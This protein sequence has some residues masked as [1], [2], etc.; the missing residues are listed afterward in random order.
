VTGEAGH[1]VVVVTSVVEVSAIVVVGVV[2][3]GTEEVLIGDA[4]CSA[5]KLLLSTFPVLILHFP[6]LILHPG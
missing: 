4:F 6:V 1:G 3:P 2:V 5:T